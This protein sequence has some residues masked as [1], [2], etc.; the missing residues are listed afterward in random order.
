[1]K[2]CDDWCGPSFNWS[3]RACQG[4]WAA[5]ENALS[6]VATVSLRVGTERAP[7]ILSCIRVKSVRENPSSQNDSWRLFLRRHGKRG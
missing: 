7:P 6:L 2:D 4:C 5:G 1:M 3:S